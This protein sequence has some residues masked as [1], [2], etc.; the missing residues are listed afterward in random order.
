MLVYVVVGAQDCSINLFL[1]SES[2]ASS[3]RSM[4]LANVIHSMFATFI[5]VLDLVESCRGGMEQSSNALAAMF[6][7]KCLQYRKTYALMMARMKV[8]QGRLQL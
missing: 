7:P 8:P 2:G 6:D 5:V 4:I 3:L 1:A